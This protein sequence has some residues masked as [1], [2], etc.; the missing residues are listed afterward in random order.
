MRSTFLTFATLF[1][2]ATCVLA[3]TA[4]DPATDAKSKQAVVTKTIAEKRTSF[5]QLTRD[6]KYDEALK[7]TDEAAALPDI[8]EQAKNEFGVFKKSQVLARMDKIDDALAVIEASLAQITLTSDVRA[9]LLFHASRLYD[10]RFGMPSKDKKQEQVMR[11]KGIEW[12]QKAADVKDASKTI[13]WKMLSSL[14]DACLTS[15]ADTDT[16]ALASNELLKLPDLTIKE[17][18]EAGNRKVAVA[19]NR[20]MPPGE[21]NQ[22]KWKLENF[23]EYIKSLE[24][25]SQ[26]APNV[27]ELC[28]IQ[29][30]CGDL[31]MVFAKDESAATAKWRLVAGNDKAPPY[32]RFLSMDKLAHS[33][34]C[35]QPRPNHLMA[36]FPERKAIPKEL[37]NRDK[38]DE[39]LAYWR[40]SLAL[41]LKSWV[42]LDA[43]VGMARAYESCGKY[44]EGLEV[45]RKNALTLPDLTPRQAAEV[46]Y[47]MAQLAMASNDKKQAA[48]L[49]AEAANTQDI[50][51][52]LADAAELLR[53]EATR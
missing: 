26:C 37:L 24:E 52:Q 49:C 50:R 12:L 8:P 10:P 21:I 11:A 17:K 38:L 18:W 5:D 13:R 4:P 43:L 41:N 39:A 31:L 3:E 44:S 23:P 1:C 34:L 28:R 35:R 7:L 19:K 32:F 51:P 53:K 33:V 46:K 42:K 30:L 27:T 25:Q 29:L 16:A 15:A 45:L 14:C 36:A 9:E 40:Q 47:I 2:A 6:K 20:A 48:S 22:A